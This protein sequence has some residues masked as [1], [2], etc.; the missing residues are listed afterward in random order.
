MSTHRSPEAI[1]SGSSRNGHCRWCG[2]E[3]AFTPSEYCVECHA[4][5]RPLGYGLTSL[6]ILVKSLAIPLALGV[7]TCAFANWQQMNLRAQDDRQKLVTA[8]G[9]FSAAHSAY[10]QASSEIQF[11][12]MRTDQNLPGKDLRDAVLRLDQAFDSIAG[13]LTPFEQYDSASAGFKIRHPDGKTD[14]EETWQ[15][16]FIHPYFSD[17]PGEPSYW[18]RIADQ[19]RNCS[20]DHCSR[21]TAMNIKQVIDQLESGACRDGVPE[22]NRGFLWFWNE[23]KRVMA[24]D[25]RA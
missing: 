9:D 25:Q 1:A 24:E 2:A 19:M 20:T 16:C 11:L 3:H 21:D 7:M 4:P 17:T 10:R 5:R 15:N 12:A 6:S 23:L 18:R 14:L 8:Y 22:K 13:K